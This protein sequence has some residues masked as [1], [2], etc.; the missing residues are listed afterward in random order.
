[1]TT[2][3][4]LHVLEKSAFVYRP[5]S[6]TTA[7]SL[8]ASPDGKYGNIPTVEEWKILWAT[9]DLISLQMTPK[10]M[11][12]EKPI[13]LRHKCLFYFGH[14]PTYVPSFAISW[15]RLIPDTRFLDML[16][17]KSIG[18]GATEPAYFWNIFEVKDT[19]WELSSKKLIIFI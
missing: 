11:V 14:I 19:V 12:H 5:L 9:W 1:L 2:F 4:T 13:D 15:C 18:G 8:A 7:N 6:Y 3:S 17:H 16:L 10:T